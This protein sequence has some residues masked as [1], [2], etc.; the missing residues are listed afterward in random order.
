MLPPP[1]GPDRLEG[2]D[3][4]PAELQP[5]LVGPYTFP[6]T[7]RRRI[8]AVMY[9]LLGAG[10]LG[11]WATQRSS[12]LVNGG[13]LLVGVVLMV[14]AGWHLLAAWPLRVD[15]LD[16]L[17]AAGASVG[18]PVG[19]ASAS[20]AWRGL[21]SRPVWRILLY[22]TESP[23]PLQRAIVVVDGVD[24]QILLTYKEPNPEDWSAFSLP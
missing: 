4:L 5:G 2:G 9:A 17:A 3:H 18:F 21:R 13:F 12:V 20:L 8:P 14:L 23:Q 1:S 19:P 7:G 11:L 6:D 22:S 15:E 24:A 16:A 10:C